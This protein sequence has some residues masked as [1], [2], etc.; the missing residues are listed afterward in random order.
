MEPPETSQNRQ[1]PFLENQP[2]PEQLDNIKAQ[3][4]LVLLAL[5]ALAGI[6]SEAILAAAKSLKLD[7]LLADRVGLWRLRQSSPLRKG[8]GRKKLD[9]EE[10]RALVLISCRLAQQN[11]DL[12]RRAVALLEQLTEQNKPP[13]RAALLGDYLDNFSN[14]YQERME[15]GEDSSTDDLSHLALRLLIDLLFY[16]GV[17]GARRLW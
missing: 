7:S 14:T 16:S 11:Q 10:A 17:G 9:V 13:H 6:G 12:I 1:N 3:L 5:E 15:A 2:D 8:H 4:D